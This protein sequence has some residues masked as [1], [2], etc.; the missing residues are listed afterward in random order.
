MEEIKANV[1]S[2][3]MTRQPDGSRHVVLVAT[4]ELQADI[5][6]HTLG[7]SI[8]VRYSYDGSDITWYLIFELPRIQK[9]FRV[10]INAN[11]ATLKWMDWLD[12]RSITAVRVAYYDGKLSIIPFGA[13]ILLTGLRY[14]I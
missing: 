2:I 6:R 4:N 14:E 13:P 10:P 12:E 1:Q 3:R 5:L 9:M 8:S 11:E 7:D